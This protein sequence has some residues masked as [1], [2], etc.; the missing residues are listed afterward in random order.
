M[1][2]IDKGRFV[3][4]LKRL[5]YEEAI[6]NC[7]HQLQ[8][9]GTPLSFRDPTIFFNHHHVDRIA[10][11]RLIKMLLKIDTTLLDQEMT[12]RCEQIRA[13]RSTTIFA[14]CV[15]GGVSM[16]SLIL[17]L[18]QGVRD[19][20]L[21]TMTAL[22]YHDQPLDNTFLAALPDADAKSFETHQRQ[23]LM[24]YIWDADFSQIIDDRL[25]VPLECLQKLGGGVTASVYEATVK[26]AYHGLGNYLPR[27]AV[28]VYRSTSDPELQAHQAREEAFVRHIL[29][30]R[31]LREHEH[32]AKPY[33]EFY[34]TGGLYNLITE[35][36]DTNLHR[37]M[38]NTSVQRRG[39]LWILRQMQGLTEAVQD[40]HA[41]AFPRVAHIH[42]IKPDNILVFEQENNCLKL[43][44]WG[45]A[46]FNSRTTPFSSPVNGTY[47][48]HAYLPP[49][50]H[51]GQNKTSRKHDVW[52]LGCVFFE[53]LLRFRGGTARYF[54]FQYERR[55]MTDA[56]QFYYMVNGA[57]LHI[58]ALT[59]GLRFLRTVDNGAWQPVV[60]TITRMLDVTR[61]G[62]LNADQARAGLQESSALI[63][64]AS[65]ISAVG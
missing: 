28:K 13:S 33:A 30:S 23:F 15:A 65:S 31:I 57:P 50:S 43:T 48:D 25:C 37:F 5:S 58:P 26:D 29:Q 21:A 64:L 63:S 41:S 14:I 59:T 46:T 2:R 51:Q 53:L 6:S 34:T 39:A 3:N 45:C 19:S 17:L 18:N 16:N 56:R 36:A 1:S 27:L 12:D 38:R 42:D 52:S 8:L 32:I 60:K 20:F 9:L 44:D 24:G 11:N 54:D 22:T 35:M 7:H 62:R 49:E 47:G 61:A 10:N 55:K 4:S 40:I